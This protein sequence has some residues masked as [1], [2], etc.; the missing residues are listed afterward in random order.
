M[1]GDHL[2]SISQ[3]KCCATVRAKQTAAMGDSGSVTNSTLDLEKEL[4]CSVSVPECCTC[5]YMYIA[6]RTC[7]YQSAG[8]IHDGPF[9]T[10]LGVSDLYRRPLP[11]TDSPRLF[12][13]VLRLLSQRMV[14]MA[15]VGCHKRA[16]IYLSSMSVSG[17]GHQAQRDCDYITRHVPQVASG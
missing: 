11:A 16:S 7:R 13:Y 8:T 17:A 2:P 15:G 12:A 3:I 9:M 14:L 1:N 4:S 6:Y 5:K 10:D